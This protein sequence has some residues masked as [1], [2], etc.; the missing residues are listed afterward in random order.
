[1]VAPT[2]NFVIFRRGDHRSPVFI[3]Y[4]RSFFGGTKAPPYG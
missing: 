1:M 3:I 2:M 4:N